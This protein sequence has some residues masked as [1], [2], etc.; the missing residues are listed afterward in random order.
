MT[1]ALHFSSIKINIFWLTSSDFGYAAGAG[2]VGLGY[3]AAA[4][5]AIKTATMNS[6]WEHETAE[7]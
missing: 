6:C 2:Y 5:T 3:S 7:Y 4:A 1:K